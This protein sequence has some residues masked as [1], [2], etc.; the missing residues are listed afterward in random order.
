[1]SDRQLILEA[2]QQ[3]PEEASAEEI[4]NELAMLASIQRGRE[5][6]K[7]GEGVPHSEVLKRFNS[8]TTESSGHRK[9]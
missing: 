4:L 8:W 9:H 7:R 1:M 6:I 5:Q 3:M 2:V